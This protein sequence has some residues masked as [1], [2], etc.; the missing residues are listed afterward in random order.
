MRTLFLT[1]ISGLSL[2]L[3]A[4][5]VPEIEIDTSCAVPAPAFVSEPNRL[6]AFALKNSGHAGYVNQV[7]PDQDFE[8][9]IVSSYESSGIVNVGK[10]DKPVVLVLAG[11]EPG[12][13]EINSARGAKIAKVVTFGYNAQRVDSPLEETRVLSCD[14]RILSSLGSS[15]EVNGNTQFMPERYLAGLKHIQSLTHLAE[16]SYQYSYNAGGEFTIPLDLSAAAGPKKEILNA[17]RPSLIREI[18]A[19]DMLERYKTFNSKAPEESRP[20]IDI[21]IQAMEA[22][23]LPVLRVKKK[24]GGDGRNA[25][26][27]LQPLFLETAIA[28]N[29]RGGL[30]FLQAP[31]WSHCAE[32]RH[33]QR[34]AR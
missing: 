34:E 11:Y 22:G 9:H 1:L 7:V 30:D 3:T 27:D 25:P 2:G 15:T 8:L 21:L 5:S 24:R 31:W 6:T 26:L 33:W 13:W 12:L 18:S 19:S 16:S 4:C 23:S 28:S 20:T 32:F 14:E 10:T 17:S 29:E